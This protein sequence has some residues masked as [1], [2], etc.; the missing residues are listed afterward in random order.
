MDWKKIIALLAVLAVTAE[1]ANA[2]TW[3]P[4]WKYRK[5]VNI[6]NDGAALTDYQILATADTASLISVGNMRADCG[7]I[8]FVDSDNT[9]ELN[10]WIESGCNSTSTKIWVKTPSIPAGNKTIYMYYGNPSAPSTSSGSN[11]FLFF[12]DFTGTTINTTKWSKTDPSGYITQNNQLIISNGPLNWG[13]V[14]MHSVQ[15]FNR[16]SI[17]AQAKYNS[18]CKVGA[19]YQDTTMLLWKDSTTGTSYTNFIYA[20]YFYRTGGTNGLDMYEDGAYRGTISGGW[21]TNT[22]YW[23]RQILKTGGGAMTELST[24]G[25]V[26]WTTKYNSSYSVETPLKIGF[27]H[28]QGGAVYI[29]DVLVRKY[30]S[31]EPTAT[32]FTEYSIKLYANSLPSDVNRT[33][34][35][36]CDCSAQPTCDCTLTYDASN[37]TTD[38]YAKAE[39]WSDIMLSN[40]SWILIYNVSATKNIFLK[41]WLDVADCSSFRGWACS[42]F[43]YS[44]PLEVRFYSDG[45]AVT[46][47]Y[48]G[49]TTANILR[50]QTVCNECNSY[51]YHGFNFIA[52]E[53]LKD[54]SPHSIYAYA[55]NISTGELSDLLGSPKTLSC[56]S[57]PYFSDFS[58]SGHVNY[59]NIFWNVNYISTSKINISCTLDCD[60]RMQN[61]VVGQICTPYPVTQYPG[62]G[63]CTVLNPVYN[64]TR[65]NKIVCKL[66]DF[67]DQSTV[68]WYP[69][70]P[71]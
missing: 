69:L 51:C 21:L 46:G 5:V 71:E 11:T 36:T 60:P 54:N 29:D 25:G 53:S 70:N 35:K 12:D 38:V 43:N 18:T 67:L 2:Q 33:L 44:K 9:T 64:F 55:V 56:P 58:Y 4:S 6:N 68:R 8:R 45:T 28:Y 10:Y 20:L 16:S 63:G 65:K 34:V 15:N 30:S 40:S 61:C 3:N 57:T 13:N 37:S 31:P 50:E 23:V 47:V 66:T 42:Q 7:D 49:N 62:N 41:G 59:F 26:T 17:I 14:E 24:D 39:T 19:T 27:T 32:V 22:Q 1:I 48:L 52:P